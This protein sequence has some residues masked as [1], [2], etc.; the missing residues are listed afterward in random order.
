MRLPQDGAQAVSCGLPGSDSDIRPA[1]RHGCMPEGR[2]PPQSP[3][4]EDVPFG[5]VL[6]FVFRQGPG[7]G[8]GSGSLCLSAAEFPVLREQC[9]WAFRPG[10]GPHERAVFLTVCGRGARF[11]GTMAAGSGCRYGRKKPGTKH[12]GLEKYVVPRDRIE[13]P[14][15]GFSVPCSTN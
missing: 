14:T 6:S 4:A 2:R 13:L 5:R 3:L 9:A 7:A 10:I 1:L 12:S 8:C 15:R 11:S